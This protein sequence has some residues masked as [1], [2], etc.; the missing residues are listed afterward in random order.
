MCSETRINTQTNHAEATLPSL[1]VTIRVPESYSDFVIIHE[2]VRELMHLA[3]RVTSKP[4]LP[5]PR[6]RSP[7]HQKGTLKT[8]A[9]IQCIVVQCEWPVKLQQWV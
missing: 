4:R 9:C 5:E 1:I 8:S 2:L 7:P 6:A 3:A